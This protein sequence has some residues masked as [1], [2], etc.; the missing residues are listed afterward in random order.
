MVELKDL[1]RWRASCNFT[2]D[3]DGTHV[4]NLQLRMQGTYCISHSLSMVCFRRDAG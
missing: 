3:A 1:R 4:H 2:P